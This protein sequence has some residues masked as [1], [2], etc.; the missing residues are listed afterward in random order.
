MIQSQ[1]INSQI[2]KR[3]FTICLLLP[4]VALP[5]FPDAN[6]KNFK[7]LQQILRYA[8]GH[9]P[10]KWPGIFIECSRSLDFDSG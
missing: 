7:L 4:S 6:V 10:C 1:K 3:Y 9:P 2:I 8:G 5:S